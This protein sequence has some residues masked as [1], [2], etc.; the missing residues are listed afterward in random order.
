MAVASSRSPVAGTGTYGP[1]EPLT[2]IVL[3][4]ELVKLH[5]TLADDI[6]MDHERRVSICDEFIEELG[7]CINLS[8]LKYLDDKAVYIRVFDGLQD[9]I[10]LIHGDQQGLQGSD[11]S[12]RLMDRQ[13]SCLAA[14]DRLTA[15]IRDLQADITKRG[16]Q[17]P[18]ADPVV[19]VE[20]KAATETKRRL[21]E[22]LTS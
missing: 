5:G 9:V 12:P 16:P 10:N 19:T 2:F 22:G 6:M 13:E 17:S 15:I 1:V 14:S 20:S 8:I 7:L 4:E 3:H 11:G 21:R 18:P